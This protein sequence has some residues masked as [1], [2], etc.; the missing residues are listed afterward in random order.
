MFTA[1]NFC[2]AFLSS[3][4]LIGAFEDTLCVETLQNKQKRCTNSLLFFSFHQS[5]NGAV[6]GSVFLSE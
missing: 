4:E 1:H 2:T 5:T 6:P 3:N